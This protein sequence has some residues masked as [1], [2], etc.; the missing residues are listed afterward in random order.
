VTLSLQIR[1]VV[2]NLVWGI[3][4]NDKDGVAREMPARMRYLEHSAYADWAPLSQWV[5]V[6]D[7]Y[8]SPESSLAARASG[9]G[10]QPPGFS[11]H[12]F[13][14]AVDVALDAT[15]TNLAK[16]RGAK[17]VTKPELDAELAEYGWYCHRTD[18]KVGKSKIHPHDESW[19]YNH[20]GRGKSTAG[21]RSTA[22][23]VEAQIVE[24]YGA[25]LYLGAPADRPANAQAALKRLGMYSG[26]IDGLF[27]PIS[28]QGLKAFQRA[29]GLRDTG[30]L[31]DRTCRTLA[32]VSSDRPR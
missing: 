31:D 9:R 12:N 6:S 14:E 17:R 28:T 26:R 25:A 29:W 5:V 19:H 18:G 13:G 27:G 3:Y 10:A 7:M 20:L 11:A 32:Y 23:W 22:A 1:P 4:D 15:M 21:F 2:A 16:L 30:K 24:R 8:R